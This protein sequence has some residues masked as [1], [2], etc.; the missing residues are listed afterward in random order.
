MKLEKRSQGI[1][2][3]SFDY[4]IKI[5]GSMIFKWAKSQNSSLF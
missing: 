3:F 1:L 2:L 4:H 5:Q